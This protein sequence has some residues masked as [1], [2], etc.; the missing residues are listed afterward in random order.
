M[1][2][3]A[4]GNESDCFPSVSKSWA[5]KGEAILLSDCAPSWAACIG[6]APFNL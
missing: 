6:N 3:V 5:G 1:R 4:L 2:A